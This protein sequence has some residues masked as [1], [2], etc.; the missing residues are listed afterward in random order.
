[1]STKNKLPPMRRKIRELPTDI[2][3]DDNPNEARNNNLNAEGTTGFEFPEFLKT[4]AN[5]QYIQLYMKMRKRHYADGA[6]NINVDNDDIADQN[7]ELYENKG[8]N[9][10]PP[11][12]NENLPDNVEYFVESINRDSFY[13]IPKKF[14][15]EFDE[16]KSAKSLKKEITSKKLAPFPDINRIS[17]EQ[18]FRSFDIK[19][20]EIIEKTTSKVSL[21]FL[22]AQGL[23]AGI[24]LNYF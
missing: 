8:I 12:I 20:T 1:M 7:F 22:F 2:K 24:F 23:L 15:H 21:I 4:N 9:I 13:K 19:L 18:I 10:E 6:I 17:E 3:E 14:H 16:S 5:E 11:I